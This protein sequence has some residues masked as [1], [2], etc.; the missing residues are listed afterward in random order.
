MKKV[1]LDDWLIVAY[2]VIS[3][4]AFITYFGISVW[5]TRRLA[6]ALREAKGVFG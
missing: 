2:L 3:S 6:G 4:A 1:H 5:R